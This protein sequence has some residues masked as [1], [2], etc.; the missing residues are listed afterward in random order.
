[1]PPKSAST[2][3]AATREFAS[4]TPKTIPTIMQNGVPAKISDY[5][6][7]NTLGVRQMRDKLPREVFEK[8]VVSVR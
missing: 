4:R 6:G 5:F 2:R 3:K 7:V 1:M 8:L